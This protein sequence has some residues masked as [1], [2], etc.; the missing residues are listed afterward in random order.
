MAEE[1]PGSSLGDDNNFVSP[2][3]PNTTTFPLL[4]SALSLTTRPL[5]K[6]VHI[7]DLIFTNQGPLLDVLH[8]PF[9]PLSEDVSQ[10]NPV[11]AVQSLVPH[12]QFS[13]LADDPSTMEQAGIAMGL[14]LLMEEMQYNPVDGSQILVLHMQPA[15]F[16]CE[17]RV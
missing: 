14:Q 3:P 5:Y 17:P 9:V 16:A 6:S 10:N 2:S 7:P 11:D 4:Q 8:C 15:G 12:A 13:A 1:H